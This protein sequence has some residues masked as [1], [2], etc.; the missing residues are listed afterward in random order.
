MWSS[1]EEDF[2]EIE[3]E[4]G[5]DIDDQEDNREK[6]KDDQSNHSVEETPGEREQTFRYDDIYRFTK[7]IEQSNGP[8][9]VEFKKPYKPAFVCFMDLIFAISFMAINLLYFWD[10]LLLEQKTNTDYNQF[11]PVR[12]IFFMVFFYL[13]F[14][15]NISYLILF[16]DKTSLNRSRST[17]G[18]FIFRIAFDFFVVTLIMFGAKY[19]FTLQYRQLGKLWL[20]FGFCK[21]AYETFLYHASVKPA[22][23]RSVY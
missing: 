1:D 6:D 8:F 10:Q 14:L 12:I 15:L 16:F 13:K 5:N 21:I 23:R 9:Q 22:Y 4:T 20:W 11:L 18:L 17:G 19:F 2:T 3:I 7:S